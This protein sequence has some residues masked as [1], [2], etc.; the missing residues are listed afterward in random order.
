M[1]TS[2][3]V[4]GVLISPAS[5]QS[6]GTGPERRPE[7][8]VSPAEASQAPGARA[9][10]LP[11]D[12]RSRGMVWEGLTPG[13]ADGPCRGLFEMRTARGVSCTHGPD[14]PPLELDVTSPQPATTTET[15]SSLPCIGNGTDGARVQAIYARPAD[16]PDRYDAIAASMRDAAARVDQVFIDSAAE[17]GGVRHVRWVTDTACNLVIER[18]QLSSAG[19]DTINNT[20]SELQA[21][22]FDRVDRKY[23][24]W[25]D[26]TVYCGIGTIRGDDQPGQANLNNGGPSYARVDSGCWGLTNPVEAHELMHNLG[27][28]QWATPN[29]SMYWHCSDDW[30]RMC[31]QDEASVTMTYTCAISH[32]RLFD[33]N[34]DDYFHTSPSPG[35]YLATHWNAA[36]SKFLFDPTAPPPSTTTS[37]TV[38]TTTASPQT[39]TSTYSG[40]LSRKQASRSYDVA[41]GAGTMTLTMTFTK[42][43]SMTITVLASD[44][45]VVAQRTGGSRITLIVPVT[46]GAY[47]VTVAAGGA[48]ASYSL[49]LTYPRVS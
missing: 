44:S 33:C 20:Q 36:S 28:V 3:A 13:R 26:S 46:T 29:G 38:T 8:V 2:I 23:L 14:T 42:A 21:I 37:S 11:A 47:R 17:T 32:E 1:A 25:M 27:G 10:G 39:A 34:H 9:D 24:I 41:T 7:H 22:G 19:D 30:D 15:S 31:Y 43:S 35:S 18:V 49:N 48:N 6:M 45:T 4:A 5:G 12:D 16:T 40:S